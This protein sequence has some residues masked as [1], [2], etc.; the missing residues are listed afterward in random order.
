MNPKNRPVKAHKYFSEGV[1][2]GH[3]RHHYL[4]KLT[5]A[6]FTKDALIRELVIEG[7]RIDIFCEYI[8]GGDPPMWF[9][10]DMLDFQDEHDEGLI[11]GF[12]GS[13]KTN[14]LTIAR[15]LFEIIKNPN[16]R[17]LFA[18]DAADQAKTFL[19]GVKSHF[20]SNE[21]LN[22][23]FGD[24]YTGAEKWTDGE[25]IVNQRTAIGLKESTITCIGKETSLLGRHFEWIIADDIVTEDNSATEGQRNKTKNYFYKTLMPC[26][27]PDGKFFIIGTRWHEQDL[28]GWLAA[29]DYKNATYTLGVIDDETDLSIWEDRFYTERMHRIRKGNLAAFELQ[30]MC[31]SGVSLGGIFTEEHFLYYDIP[32]KNVF[33]WQAADLAIGQKTRNDFFA[34][35]TIAVEKILKDVYL[36]QFR[37]TK[38][39]FPRQIEF[40]KNRFDEFPATVR[41]GIEANAYQIALTQAV[42]EKYPDIPVVPRYTLK[43]KVARAQQLATIATDKPFHVMRQHHKF[44]RRLCS[45]PNGPKDVFDSFE[46]AVNMGLGGVRKKRREEP[47]LI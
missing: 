44:I 43:D 15:A 35:S 29:E 13:R 42:K 11:L 31:R 28:Y 32:P 39:P 5:Q 1:G 20:K 18:A 22:R 3:T 7:N 46:I 47:G 41:V 33:I 45:F 4:D 9:H 14:Y 25:I 19:R 17:I 27:E 6:T 34:H 36:L 10:R 40:I 12:R 38:I 16:I 8:M 26:L 23:I 21:E 2:Y 30:W 24:Y 37:E